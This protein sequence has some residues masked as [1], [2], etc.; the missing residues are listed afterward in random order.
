MSSAVW[1]DYSRAD[2]WEA[3]Y[4]SE[5]GIYDWY[6]DWDEFFRDELESLGVESP[7]LIVGCGNSELSMRIE[8]AG[9][10]PVVSID[11]SPTC[12]QKMT[13]R[14]GGCYLPMDVCRMQFRSDIFQCAI[15]KG[16]LDALLCSADYEVGCAKMIQ[17]I[18][19]VLAP[20]GIFIEVTFG[21]TAER[22]QVLDNPDLLPWTLEEVR[23]V[24]AAAG[25]ACVLVFR[26]FKQV[27][28][29]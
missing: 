25:T 23:E 14:F 16:T 2:Y 27:I 19:R 18:A 8:S 9:V 21:K 20:N 4:K 28:H 7:V 10:R 22:I 29:E 6:F 17:E 15:D 26:K 3:R 5:K 1:K 12:C 13:T 11:I 24:K